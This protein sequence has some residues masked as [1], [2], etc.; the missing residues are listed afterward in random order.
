M[1]KRLSPG[2]PNEKRPLRLFDTLKSSPD[3]TL[4]IS[5][6][7]FPTTP[8]SSR[9]GLFGA[10]TRALPLAIERLAVLALTRT[11]DEDPW[12]LSF[13]DRLLPTSRKLLPA[14]LYRATVESAL[15]G[16]P[17]LVTYVHA[18]SA[19]VDGHL[20]RA[21][22]EGCD[23]VVTLSPGFDSRSLRLGE[24]YPWVTF[25][26]I[27]STETI[28]R[29]RKLI[30]D[31]LQS[32]SPPNHSPDRMP[33]LIALDWSNPSALISKLTSKGFDP[34]RKCVCII[35]GLIPHLTQHQVEG[36]LSDV[37]ALLAPASLI[38]WDFL[39]LDAF[40][41]TNREVHD[42]YEALA[43]AMANKG[44]PFKSGQVATF[45]ELTKLAA[46]RQLRII[47][48][49][50]PSE[51]LKRTLSRKERVE[52][53]GSLG[54]E[55]TKISAADVVD[56]WAWPRPKPDARLGDADQ[57]VRN[58]VAC[59]SPCCRT[60]AKNARIPTFYSFVA[61]AK[62]DSRLR[63]KQMVT[64]RSPRSFHPDQAT[65]LRQGP[66][67]KSN[68]RDSS[69]DGE[70]YGHIMD[71][72]VTLQSVKSL[73]WGDC[74]CSRD[75]NEAPSRQQGASS[76]HLPHKE[77]RPA[78]QL[79]S[80]WSLSA[81]RADPRHEHQRRLGIA[82]ATAARIDDWQT[83]VLV[84]PSDMAGDSKTYLERD[85]FTFEG[86]LDHAIS[87]PSDAVGQECRSGHTSDDEQISYSSR[88]FGFR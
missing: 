71:C 29:K 47:Q 4:D 28:S 41:G 40:H 10:A 9:W 87:L 63:L 30:E 64:S 72:F 8:P 69:S 67:T 24:R 17:G 44:E 45:A 82:P 74:V 80:D 16:V 35:E 53:L 62:I 23:Q 7:T 88:T 34:D 73:L 21:I 20:A 37:A 43:T 38:L 33:R 25:Y 75:S 61:A 12:G 66:R 60:G 59:V 14:S 5:S 50:G 51:I 32:S 79:S 49:L 11:R 55:V 18:R 19:W 54:K 36:L 85:G 84:P 68:S 22:A 26:E 3:A 86:S 57:S 46:P 81:P 39:H 77:A 42:G 70:L 1:S 13:R 56:E 76:S 65:Q 6:R 83:S 78:R 2:D 31:I 15:F 58:G 27:D 52:S 48:H